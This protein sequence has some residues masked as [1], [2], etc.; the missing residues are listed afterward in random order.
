LPTKSCYFNPHPHTEDDTAL[1]V[2]HPAIEDFNPH[3]H[4][5][6]DIDIDQ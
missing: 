1:A 4:T 2:W 5:E 6:D 3:P